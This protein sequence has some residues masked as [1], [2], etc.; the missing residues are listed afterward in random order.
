LFRF[1]TIVPALSVF[2]VGALETESDL[3][4]PLF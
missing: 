4:P 1:A 2:G 3:K